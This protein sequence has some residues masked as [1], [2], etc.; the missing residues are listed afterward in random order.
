VNVDE[1]LHEERRR[2]RELGGDREVVTIDRLTRD[3]T[4]EG[5]LV[6]LTAVVPNGTNLDVSVAPELDHV[7]AFEE[8]VQ[9]HGS[10]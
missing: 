1:A 4:E 3:A 5:A 9:A 10:S 7:A 8:V 2:A 6:D